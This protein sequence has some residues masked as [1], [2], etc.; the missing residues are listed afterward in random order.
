MAGDNFSSTETENKMA[1]EETGFRVPSWVMKSWLIIMDVGSLRGQP[2]YKC[3]YITQ[4]KERLNK[5][6]FPYLNNVT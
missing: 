5:T 2:N 4:G 1:G 3:M 6:T